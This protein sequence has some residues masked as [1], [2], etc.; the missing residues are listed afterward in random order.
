[1]GRQL[2]TLTGIRGVAAVW[3]VFFHGY[4]YIASLLGGPDR[5][6]VPI[7]RDG[8]LGVDLFFVLSGFVLSL[9]YSEHFQRNFKSAIIG[10]FF[11]RF[12]RIFPLHWVC[13]AIFVLL[14][15][16]FPENYWGPGP[17][18]LSALAAS[19]ALVQNWIPSTALAWNDPTWS[20][21]AELAAYLLFPLLTFAIS[22]LR[23]RRLAFCLALVSLLTLALSLTV[24]KSQSLNHAGPPGIV[25][26]LFEFSAGALAWKS[27]PADAWKPASTEDGSY[28]RLGEMC[29]VLGGAVLLLALALPEILVIAPVAFMMFILGCALSSRTAGWLFGN[30]VVVF[31]GNISFSIYLVHLF[32][33]GC[34]TVVISSIQVSTGDW[35]A[36]LG[37]CVAFPP[38]VLVTAY[39]TWRFVERPTHE[40]ARRHRR[41]F[42][43]RTL[44][45]FGSRRSLLDRSS[46]A[47]ATLTLWVMRIVAMSL[48]ETAGDF[49]STT[50]GVGFGLS[51][52]ILL[53]VFF[54]TLA[55]HVVARQSYPLLSWT[56]ILCSTMAGTTM[57]D[58]LFGVAGRGGSLLLLI[59]VLGVGH[60]AVGPASADHTI[61]P[62]IQIFYWTT[63]LILSAFG[64]SMGDFLVHDVGL[65]YGGGGLLLC[66]ALAGVV[67]AYHFTKLSLTR[68]FWTRVRVDP[69]ARHDGGRHIDAAV[70]GRW[71]SVGYRR[72][73][74]DPGDHLGAPHFVLRPRPGRTQRLA[75]DVECEGGRA[76][77]RLGKYWLSGGRWRAVNLDG[78][79]ERR[80]VLPQLEAAD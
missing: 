3:V 50:S 42:T 36:G 26:C 12:W 77:K 16:L 63:F 71:S 44:A 53:V 30:T 27:I 79:R 24:R 6:Q 75:F 29:M 9:A 32:V 38:L 4:V 57:S 5:S 61:Q 80:A 21:S 43:S 33:L 70:R 28:R 51:T 39:L 74:G 72:R 55:V 65:G 1:M 7:I 47:P 45:W 69:I 62:K 13:L 49:L 67:L 56:L 22:R 40:F 18:T 35:L 34:L 37:A 14:V 46:P 76:R 73:L 23:D 17:F 20:L 25:R 15:E 60:F 64:T 31:L 58:F 2:V 11:A 10:F 48:G 66:G 52:S 19:A 8:Y 78:W 54:A 59:V 41:G 68:L